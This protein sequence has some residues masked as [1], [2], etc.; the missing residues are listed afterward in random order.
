MEKMIDAGGRL[1]A[2][3]DLAS[4]PTQLHFTPITLRRPLLHF[5]QVLGV[6]P[7]LAGAPNPDFLVYL[8][9]GMGHQEQLRK[10]ARKQFKNFENFVR[11]AHV[12]AATTW[13]LLLQTLQVDEPTLRSFAHGSK[14][15]PLVP[16]YVALFELLERTF[17]QSFRASTLGK[18]YCRCCGADMLNDATVWWQEQQPRVAADAATFVDRLLTAVLG[19]VLLVEGIGRWLGWSCLA[20]AELIKLAAPCHHPMGHWMTMVRSHRGLRHDWEL[21]VA[22]ELA[23]PGPAVEGRL[24]KWRCGQGLLPMDKAL[25][26]IARAPDKTKLKHALFAA[27]TLSLA[28][29]VVQAAAETSVRPDRETAQTI[30]NARLQQLHTH[31][32]LARAVAATPKSQGM[33]QGA[34]GKD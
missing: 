11:G 28:I 14:N 24:R 20:S 2:L 34:D 19:G 9:E 23:S 29:D 13:T 27:R 16:M 22:S 21:T 31:F 25:L 10:T 4:R 15:G 30:V 3:K 17:V 1:E 12:P 18:V 5:H 33:A 6:Q 32:Q 26:M 8:L 7:G